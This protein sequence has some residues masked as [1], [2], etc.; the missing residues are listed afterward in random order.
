MPIRYVVISPVRNEAQYI[1]K[2]ISSMLCQTISPVAWVLVNDGSTDDTAKIIDFWASQ[3]DW[4]IPVHRADPSRKTPLPRRVAGEKPQQ[5]GRRAREAKE[6]EAFYTGFNQLQCK[7]WDFLVKLD[8]DVGFEP[9]YFERCFQEFEIDQGLG[10]GG[11]VICHV[12]NGELCVEVTSRFH[13]RGATKI[14]RRACWDEIGG[15]IRGAGWDTLDEAKANMRGWTSRSFDN[16][17]IAH[18]RYTGAANGQWQNWVKNGTWNYICGYH[19]AFMLLKCVKRVFTKPYIVSPVGLLYGFL[20]G[21]IQK[22]PQVDDHE[23]IRYV[24][25]QQLRRLCFRTTIWK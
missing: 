22:I 12:I 25:D 4:I 3:R 11:G 21:W 1:E 8:G 13:V 19:P 24:K 17:A 5:R 16:V 18:Y 10:I 23:L 20:L 2:T 9:D 14:Y 7:D 6:I 15:V